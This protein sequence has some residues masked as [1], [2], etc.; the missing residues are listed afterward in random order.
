MNCRKCGDILKLTKETNIKS[1]YQ[2]DKNFNV[3]LEDTDAYE[4]IYFE[5]DGCG[6]KYKIS[7][8][9]NGCIQSISVDRLFFKPYS[10]K[11]V[12]NGYELTED[13]IELEEIL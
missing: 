13:D 9:D 6:Q 5:C 7:D 3:I 8:N 12:D 11:T 10:N 2:I 4:D 1:I